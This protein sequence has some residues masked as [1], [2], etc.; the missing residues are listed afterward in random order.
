MILLR[1]R[2]GGLILTFRRSPNGD[3]AFSFFFSSQACIPHDVVTGYRAVKPP[4]EP[5]FHAHGTVGYVRSREGFYHSLAFGEDP[6]GHGTQE[7]ARSEVFADIE[8][9]VRI[10]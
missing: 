6:A 10:G 3:S 4:T 7:Q 5:I 9:G 8:V 2:S 1:D